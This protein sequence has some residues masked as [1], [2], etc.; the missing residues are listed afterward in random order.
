[1]G[2][3]TDF[4]NDLTSVE[5]KTRYQ[6]FKCELGIDHVLVLIPLKEAKQ[7][8]QEAISKQPQT[9]AQLKKLV[10]AYSGLFEEG[11]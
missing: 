6:Q 11:N 1:M 5:Q 2:N 10:S 7:F 8:E 4:L 9:R 3:S